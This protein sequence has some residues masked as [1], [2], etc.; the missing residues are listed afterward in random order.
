MTPAYHPVEVTLSAK[1]SSIQSVVQGLLGGVG[2][3]V[4]ESK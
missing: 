3:A 4:V 1:N 2:Q